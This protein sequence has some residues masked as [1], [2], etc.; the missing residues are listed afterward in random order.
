MTKGTVLQR[1]DGRHALELALEKQ[2]PAR[3]AHGKGGILDGS[4]VCL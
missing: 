4:V 1:R 3:L 2:M